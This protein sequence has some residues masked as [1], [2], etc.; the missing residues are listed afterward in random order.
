MGLGWEQE[1]PLTP[2]GWV[3]TPRGSLCRAPKLSAL[4][5]VL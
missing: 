3:F 4:S 2:L 5:P 1:E